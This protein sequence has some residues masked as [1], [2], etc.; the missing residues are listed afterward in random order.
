MSNTKEYI[1]RLFAAHK[2]I[3]PS[4]RNAMFNEF[5]TTEQNTET[6]KIILESQKKMMD[7]WIVKNRI[8]DILEHPIQI[9]NGTVGKLYESKFD[10]I[11]LGWNDVVFSEFEG[12]EDYGLHYDNQSEL[13]SGTPSQNGEFKIK[14]KF[15]VTGEAEDSILNEKII[16]LII[17]A[18]PKSLWKN[19]E[20]D[21][22]DPF[23][24]AD[25][26][27]EFNS[28]LMLVLLEMMIMLINILKIRA[29][30]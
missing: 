4:N 25:N 28:L 2:I 24:K 27:Q 5:V 15:R 14:L 22:N 7:K 20:S 11:Q 13:I 30:V 21:K 29:G 12:L 1:E 8:A 16:N 6:V 3:I 10:F 17:N 26:A 18:D 23:W 9:P 19:L